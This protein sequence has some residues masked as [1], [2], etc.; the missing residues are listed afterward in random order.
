MEGG[1][2]NHHQTVETSE[3]SGL[4]VSLT[5]REGASTHGLV[6]NRHQ[7]H[8]AVLEIRFHLVDGLDPDMK[9]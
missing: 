5:V 1:N 4:S 3:A 2:T 8:V 7:E 6:E 9:V